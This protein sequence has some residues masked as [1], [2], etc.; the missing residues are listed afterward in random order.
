MKKIILLFTVA[1]SILFT[2]CSSDDDNVGP[3]D[4]QD[5]F[6]GVWKITQEFE[7][8]V[9]VT[10]ATCDLQ[11]VLTVTEDEKFSGTS[12]VMENG[13][14]V[15][16]DTLTGVWENLGDNKYKITPDM[17]GDEAIDAIITFSGNTM[18]LV[19]NDEDG[20]F[21]QVLTRI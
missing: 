20:E 1:S 7:D 10:V 16:E 19:T 3:V 21:K 12:H 9:E 8:G 15:L 2:S 14:C 6:I 11:D 18:T 4:T 17:D 13:S 5:K